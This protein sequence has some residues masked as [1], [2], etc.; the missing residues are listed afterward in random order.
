MATEAR[1]AEEQRYLLY[2]WSGVEVELHGPFATDEERVVAARSL[3]S[4]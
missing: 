3:A 1:G 2:V 4:E